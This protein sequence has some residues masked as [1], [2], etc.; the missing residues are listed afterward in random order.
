MLLIFY[1]KVLMKGM[2]LL[3][4]KTSIEVQRGAVFSDSESSVI[5]NVCVPLL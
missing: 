3:V 1:S 5:I 2:E 4:S